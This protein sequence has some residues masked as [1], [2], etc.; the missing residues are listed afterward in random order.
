[1]TGWPVA[2]AGIQVP[3]ESMDLLKTEY[4]GGEESKKRQACPIFLVCLGL[5]NRHIS[6]KIVKFNQ[7]S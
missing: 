2:L 6:C 4:T 3:L 7:R 1:M 5:I